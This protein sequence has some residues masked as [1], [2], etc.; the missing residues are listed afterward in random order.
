MVLYLQRDVAL[1]NL[2]FSYQPEAVEEKLWT[3]SI[4][5]SPNALSVSWNCRSGGQFSYLSS[6]LLQ[7]H[8][9]DHFRCSSCNF[10]SLRLDSFHGLLGRISSH[11]TCLLIWDNLTIRKNDNLLVE[12]H[13]SPCVFLFCEQVYNPLH[14]RW[15]HSPLLLLTLKAQMTPIW[16][17]RS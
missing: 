3:W 11:K 8:K 6:L 13:L 14:P 15:S 12:K 2:D 10:Y 7:S 5:K 17:G 16:V 1:W 9:K 4:S